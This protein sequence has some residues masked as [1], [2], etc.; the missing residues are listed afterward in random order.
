MTDLTANTRGTRFIDRTGQQFPHFTVLRLDRVIRTEKSIRT[1]WWC[2]CECRKIWSANAGQLKH[3]KSCGC[4]A[5]V[6]LLKSVTTHGRK[7]TVEHNTWNRI[8]QRCTNSNAP[9]YPRY[10]GRGIQMCERW[11]NSFEAF[12]ADMG[13]RPGKGYSIERKENNGHYEP[14]NCRWATA[15]EQSNNRRNNHP[16]THNGKTLTLTQWAEIK[17]M[18]PSTLSSRFQKDMGVEDALNTP[19]LRKKNPQ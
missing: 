14:D 3:I 6:A 19:I 9:D 2:E 15:K 18:N 5:R 1:Y 4:L 13:A 7:G 17:K 16:V 10:G 11:R 8:Q 12:Y